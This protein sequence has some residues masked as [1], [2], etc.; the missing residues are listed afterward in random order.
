MANDPSD[1]VT[2]KSVEPSCLD[3]IAKEFN[4]RLRPEVISLED[5]TVFKI[6]GVDRDAKFL[7]EIFAHRGALKAGQRKKLANDLL[8]LLVLEHALG[9]SWCKVVCV[10]DQHAYDFLSGSS[11]CAKAMGVFRFKLHLVTLLPEIRQALQDAQALQ[12][13]GARR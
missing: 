5:G 13:K 3:A 6:D 4:V 8:K 7:C 10:V 11:W 1:S 2:Q 9:G 12:A